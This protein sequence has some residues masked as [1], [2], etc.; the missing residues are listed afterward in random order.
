MKTSD[1]PQPGLCKAAAR[2]FVLNT[3]SFQVADGPVEISGYHTPFRQARFPR[4]D[5]LDSVLCQCL[6][7]DDNLL[8]R[9]YLLNP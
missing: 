6:G 8:E 1:S 4:Q 5:G 2:H 9:V 7:W 3:A